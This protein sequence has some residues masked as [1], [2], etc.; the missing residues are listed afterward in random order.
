MGAVADAHDPSAGTAPRMS[1]GRIKTQPSCTQPSIE[2]WHF[3]SSDA[4]GWILTMVSLRALGVS[5]ALVAAVP[6]QAR[7]FRSSDIYPA[8]YPTVQAVVQMD[9]LMRERSGGQQG[10]TVLGHHDRDTES[11]AVV[12]VRDGKLDMARVNIA[13][14]DKS[15]PTIIP[16]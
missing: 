9:K 2:W 5:L 12:L 4:G 14:L 6:A 13:V 11:D 1:V 7:E 8:D 3:L 15:A 10:I 16:S